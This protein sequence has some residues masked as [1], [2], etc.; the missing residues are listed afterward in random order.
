MRKVMAMTVLPAF[1]VPLVWNWL[2]CPPSTG[3]ADVDSK[4]WA[5]SAYVG[6]TWITGDFAPALWTDYDNVGPRTTNVAEGWHSSLNT[7]FGTPHH[8]LR[9]F[10]A[11]AAKVPVRSPAS[12]NSAGGR[13]VAETSPCKL[14]PG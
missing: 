3:D 7:H 9:V 1:A 4:A 6:R 5:L 10:S 12:W 11:L 2:Q 8:S 14:H 13:E